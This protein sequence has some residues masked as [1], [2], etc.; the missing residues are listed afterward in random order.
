KQVPVT[1]LSI[2]ILDEVLAPGILNGLNIKD[3]LRYRKESAKSRDAFL[4]YVV[5]MQAKIGSLSVDTDYKSTIAQL[6]DSE[7]RPAAREYKNRLA[8]TREKLF[9]AV[10]KD[11]LA[12]A[13]GVGVGTAGIE[14][15]GD[16]SWPRL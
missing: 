5:S 3:V 13:S 14:L 1:D 9:G 10:A 7:V 11:A 12:A 8:N 16:L 15:F 2:A 4:D 6:I